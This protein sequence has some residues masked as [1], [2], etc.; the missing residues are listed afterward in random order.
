[1]DRDVVAGLDD[2]DVPL[3]IEVRSS[4]EIEEFVAHHQAKQSLP[5]KAG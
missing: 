3:T 5:K 1:V 4:G 2:L